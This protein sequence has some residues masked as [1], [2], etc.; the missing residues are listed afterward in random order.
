MPQGG[1]VKQLVAKQLA[2]Y[3]PIY[4]F[5]DACCIMIDIGNALAAMHSSKPPMMH[6]DVKLDN[7]LL[8]KEPN[9]K[10]PVHAKM[11]DFGLHVVSTTVQVYHHCDTLGHSFS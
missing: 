9:G 3:N 8:T 2:N 4:T 6:R 5:N 1:S 10:D 11:A 7:M